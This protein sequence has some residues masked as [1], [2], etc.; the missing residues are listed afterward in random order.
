MTERWRER[1]TCAHFEDC[2][3]LLFFFVKGSTFSVFVVPP[4]TKKK[5]KVSFMFF[6]LFFFRS[7]SLV[8]AFFFF[9]RSDERIFFFFRPLF[10]VFFLSLSVSFCLSQHKTGSKK[11]SLRLKA[12]KSKLFRAGI[13]TKSTRE[14]RFK[15]NRGGRGRVKQRNNNVSLVFRLLD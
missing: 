3:F 12:K 2:S 14:K 5:Q 8:S 9:F 13:R 10:F 7:A 1:E 6:A 4:P 15:K 11:I